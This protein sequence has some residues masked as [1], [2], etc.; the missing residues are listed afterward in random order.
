MSKGQTANIT[1]VHDAR[2]NISPATAFQLRRQYTD[3]DLVESYF[4][5]IA[6]PT[7]SIDVLLHWTILLY[8]K[9]LRSHNIAAHILKSPMWFVSSHSTHTNKLWDYTL[10]LHCN[11]L[12]YL[13]FFYFAFILLAASGQCFL[14]GA[15]RVLV[16]LFLGTA[17][18]TLKT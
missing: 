2:Q 11:F 7:G 4:K 12:Y 6:D 18:P 14:P 5:V 17:F 10:L 3:V 16:H 15:Q 8:W 13:C 1:T 9:A